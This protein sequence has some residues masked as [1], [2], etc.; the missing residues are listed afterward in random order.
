MPFRRTTLKKNGRGIG[1]SVHKADVGLADGWGDVVVD[2]HQGLHM[3][4]LADCDDRIVGL[5]DP[6]KTDS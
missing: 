1:R 2:Q 3:G 4:Q 5:G 6:V